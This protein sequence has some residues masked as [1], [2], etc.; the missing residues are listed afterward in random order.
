MKMG[1]FFGLII[2]AAIGPASSEEVTS[3]KKVANANYRYSL[4]TSGYGIVTEDDLAYDHC[5]RRILPY[6]PR[7]ASSS[8]YWQCFPIKDVKP[9]YSIS[10]D[11]DP[12]GAWNIIVTMCNLEIIVHHHGE[13]QIYVDH[14][15]HHVDYCRD[16]VRKWLSLTKD[17]QIVCLNG[18]GGYYHSDEKDGKYKL[19]TWEKF[20]TKKGCHSYFSGECTT[21]GYSKGKCPSSR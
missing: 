11:N 2:M 7:T 21:Y 6:N 3:K 14:R 16:F 15:G 4:L 8:L 10:Y 17:Q 1:F 12:M 18:D 5:Q 9:K 13:K 19:W 20:K